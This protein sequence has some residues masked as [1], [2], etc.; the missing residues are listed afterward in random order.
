MVYRYESDE[1]AFLEYPKPGSAP[2]GPAAT[3][4]PPAGPS[5]S[6]FP[7]PSLPPPPRPTAQP[8]LPPAGPDEQAGPDE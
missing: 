8:A 1:D 7:T 4:P 3:T 5:R 2:N 6:R